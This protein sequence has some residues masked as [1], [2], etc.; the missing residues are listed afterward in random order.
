[1]NCE[2]LPIGPSKQYSNV[3]F[4]L[5]VTHNDGEPLILKELHRSD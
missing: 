2:L 1:M 4:E 5:L 3:S